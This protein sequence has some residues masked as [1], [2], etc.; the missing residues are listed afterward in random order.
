MRLRK[1]KVRPGRKSGWNA[2]REAYR[3]LDAD[4]ERLAEPRVLVCDER[5]EA[6]AERARK[7]M[8]SGR[9]AELAAQVK[10]QRARLKRA[11]RRAEKVTRRTQRLQEA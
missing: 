7:R 2:G 8:Q 5:H 1:Q 3:R 6:A 9:A 4:M 10:R 11:L